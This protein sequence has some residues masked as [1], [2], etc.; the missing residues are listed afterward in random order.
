MDGTTFETLVFIDSVDG[1]SSKKIRQY[2]GLDRKTQ[3]HVIKP[4]IKHNFIDGI[5]GNGQRGKYHYKLNGDSIELIRL[6]VYSQTAKK[7][8]PVEIGASKYSV[9][10]ENSSEVLSS[11]YKKEAWEGLENHIR[12]RVSSDL[13]PYGEAYLKEL[14]SSF[15][16]EE[17]Q[18]ISLPPDTSYIL[19]LGLLNAGILIGREFNGVTL[20]RL[21]PQSRN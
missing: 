16:E 2:T 12:E 13:M 8:I 4:L 6:L 19:F 5:G 21:R 18:K 11:L 9:M 3:H 17:F 15:I 14:I 1:A 7:T 20:Y 10:T